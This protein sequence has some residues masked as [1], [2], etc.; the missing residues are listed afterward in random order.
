MTSREEI[1]SALM[2]ALFEV[3]G[4]IELWERFLADLT[5]FGYAVVPREA[6]EAMLHAMGQ[7][8][9]FHIPR[10]ANRAVVWAAMIA[11]SETR[12]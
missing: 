4:D 5:A 2:R 9:S 6:T 11:A 1:K 10:D 12:Q 7:A 8:A 3:D